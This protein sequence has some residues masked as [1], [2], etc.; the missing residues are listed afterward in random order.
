MKNN[1]TLK[2]LS[3]CTVLFSALSVA[4]S[5]ETVTLDIKQTEGP[6]K[7]E[8]QTAKEIETNIGGDGKWPDE[9]QQLLS[10]SLCLLGFCIEI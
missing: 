2:T 1:N 5:E 6:Q 10:Q 3:L 4:G 9:G 7:I 8:S